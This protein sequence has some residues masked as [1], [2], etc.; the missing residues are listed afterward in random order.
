MIVRAS[1][2]GREDL[3]NSN[4]DG[5]ANDPRV[6]AVGAVRSDGRAC[7]YSSPGACLLVSARSG[8]PDDGF[9]NVMTT[10]RHGSA[11]FNTTGSGDRADYGFEITGFNG[12]SASSPQIAGVAA[13]ILGA[14]RAAS[15]QQRH[16]PRSDRLDVLVG[17][18]LL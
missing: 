3:I 16:R 17:A 12:T 4:D 10:D 2:N 14:K 11:G 6:I 5:F 13:L 18:A 9:P 15:D 8:D 7:S 1:G